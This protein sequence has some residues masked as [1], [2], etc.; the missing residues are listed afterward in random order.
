M[1]PNSFDSTVQKILD[2]KK[3]GEDVVVYALVEFGFAWSSSSPGVG[4]ATKGHPLDW[5]L[6]KV[7]RDVLPRIQIPSDLKA[8]SKVGSLLPSMIVKLLS[9]ELEMFQESAKRN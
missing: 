9:L 3:R 6:S 2:I 7:L 8:N 4:V 1:P 5:E